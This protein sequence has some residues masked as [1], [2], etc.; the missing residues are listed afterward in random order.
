[1]LLFDQSRG[2]VGLRGGSQA[3]ACELAGPFNSHWS[4]FTGTESMSF[5]SF[6]FLGDAA[7]LVQMP[8]PAGDL[9]DRTDDHIRHRLIGFVA[10]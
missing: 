7:M 8:E 1:V 3:G 5:Q 4:E 9:V 10:D 6:A 2:S